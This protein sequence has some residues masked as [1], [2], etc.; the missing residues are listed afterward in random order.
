[1]S[2]WLISPKWGLGGSAGPGGATVGKYL[3]KSDGDEV[4]RH[5]GS[6]PFRGGAGL[7]IRFARFRR[8]RLSDL[9]RRSHGLG[10]REHA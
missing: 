8:D 1:M 3:A 2:D 7:P 4:N 10:V 5:R 6:H 9:R